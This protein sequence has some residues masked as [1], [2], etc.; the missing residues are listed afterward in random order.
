MDFK[1]EFPSVPADDGMAL[2]ELLAEEGDDF[3]AAA[4][5]ALLNRRPDA[6]GGPGYLQ[7]LRDGTPKLAILYDL[8]SSE[9]SRRLGAPMPGLQEAFAREGIGEAAGVIRAAAAIQSAE[10]LLIIE[11]PA[12]FIPLAYRVVLKRAADLEG[13]ASYRTRMLEGVSRTR[14]LYELY[15]SDERRRAGTQ[16]PGLREAFRREGLVLADESDSA[17]RVASVEPAQTLEQLLAHHGAS[18]IECAHVTLLKRR[19]D[20]A[21]LY[22]QLAKLR[23]GDSKIRILEEIARLPGAA[24]GVR[25]IPALS[26]ALSRHRLA[27]VPLLGGLARLR[28]WIEG[29]SP[30]ERRARAN[31]ERSFEL[32]AALADQVAQSGQ[33]NERA[34]AL[35]RQLLD[36][37]SDLDTRISSLERSCASLRKLISRYMADAPELEQQPPAAMRDSSSSRLALEVRTEEILRDLL[38]DKR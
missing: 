29:D 19:P 12:Q 1:N 7:A 22:Q 27:R 18:F 37:R 24:G 8:Y 32:A 13:I 33:A 36:L 9:E 34:E 38:T 2:R 14:I 17:S 10:Q 15:C 5:Q 31:E 20:E 3:I 16:L 28:G 35:A 4:Y 26:A 21:M 11:D 23:E 25:A 30:T 6:M